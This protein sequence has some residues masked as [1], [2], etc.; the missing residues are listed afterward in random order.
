MLFIYSLEEAEIYHY[1]FNLARNLIFL[2]GFDLQLE[3][4]KNILFKISQDI[5]YEYI[6]I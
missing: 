1:L 6:Y 5:I 2:F 4:F 3:T